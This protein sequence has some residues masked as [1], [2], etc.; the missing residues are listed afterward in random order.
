MQAVVGRLLQPSVLFLLVA[1]AN[2]IVVYYLDRHWHAPTHRRAGALLARPLLALVLL[3]ALAVAPIERCCV[4][5]RVA[6]ARSAGHAMR[7]AQWQWRVCGCGDV[8][9][10]CVMCGSFI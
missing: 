6:Q 1:S 8:G 10:R 5:A 7:N 4:V 9:R 3:R 2:A